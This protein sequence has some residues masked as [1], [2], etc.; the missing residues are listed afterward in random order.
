MLRIT[1]A[2]AHQ[3]LEQEKQTDAEGLVLRIA[4]KTNQDGSFEYGMGFDDEKEEDVKSTQFTVSIVMDP[5]SAELLD[6]ATMDFV[7]IEPG[8]HHFV[9][10][11]PL[12]PNYIPPKKEKR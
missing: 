8:Q 1:E 7:E 4:A 9:F 3:I 2:A 10:S 12:D 5:Q 6:D 11:N